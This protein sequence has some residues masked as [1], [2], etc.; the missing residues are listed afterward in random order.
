MVT[1]RKAGPPSPLLILGAALVALGGCD[2]PAPKAGPT[3]L[4]AAAEGSQSVSDRH[5][6]RLSVPCEDPE[7]AARALLQLTSRDLGDDAR[8]RLLDH[9]TDNVRLKDGPGKIAVIVYAVSAEGGGDTVTT[10]EHFLIN[11]D[12]R[13]LHWSSAVAPT[14]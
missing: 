13:V 3:A 12:C 11:G 4:A 1:P 9:A 10:T 14:P 8:T 6:S 2:G 5:F 7:A